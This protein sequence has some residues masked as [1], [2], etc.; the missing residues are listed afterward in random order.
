M[1]VGGNDNFQK[2]DVYSA[3]ISKLDPGAPA[4]RM[5]YDLFM[6]SGVAQCQSV[7]EFRLQILA[8]YCT[9]TCMV[10]IFK[11]LSE[12]AESYDEIMLAGYQ[13]FNNMLPTNFIN[14][15]FSRF[16]FAARSVLS[17]CCTP[18]ESQLP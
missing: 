4:K 5:A 14:M 7:L 10:C 2:G 18:K 8:S 9:T 17:L 6:V 12:S 11:A 13:S 1:Y 15:T 16:S 3:V